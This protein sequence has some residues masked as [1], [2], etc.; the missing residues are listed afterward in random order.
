M[1]FVVGGTM[2]QARIKLDSEREEGVYHCMSRTVN[3][4]PLLDDV[5]KEVLRKQLWQVADY[6]GLE[7]LTYTIM[8]N[9]FHVLVRVPQKAPVADAE[10]I[11]RYRT[12]YPKPTKYQSARFEA[13]Q[14]QLKSDGPD[15]MIWRNRQLAL[16]GDLSPFMRL[17]K[18]RFST[19]FNRS[20]NRYGTLWSE[21]FKS[22]LVEAKSGVMRTMA[23]Y[24]DLNA[25]RAGVVDDPKDFRFCGYGEAVAGSAVARHGFSRLVAGKKWADR[26]ANYRVMLFGKGSGPKQHAANLS[27]EDLAKVV[28]AKG[29]LPISEVLRCRVRYFSDGAVLGSRAFV[30]TQLASYQKLTGLRVRTAPRS[31]PQVADWGDLMTLR[32]L[33]KRGFG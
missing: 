13:I 22:V 14:A 33:R 15:A 12:L 6:C 23:A 25:V 26:Q 32:G 3:G 30:Q 4:E 7:I 21:R 31:V 18:Q 1:F 2:R 5:A 20:H 8:S 19:W 10:L 27:G 24:I 9:H 17:V 16:M 11:R 29:R 28:A